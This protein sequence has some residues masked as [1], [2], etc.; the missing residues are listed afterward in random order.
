MR[1]ILMETLMT[2]EIKIEL[3]KTWGTYTKLIAFSTMLE[4]DINVYDNTQ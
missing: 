1:I 2:I 3:D 4:I